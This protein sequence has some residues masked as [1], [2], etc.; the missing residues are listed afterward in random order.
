[1][2]DTSTILTEILGVLTSLAYLYF[3]VKQK[4]W[5][6]PLGILSSAFYIVI[7]Y[8]S[9]LYADMGLQVYY[10]VISVYGWY[11]WL[12]AAARKDN[13]RLAVSR[14][15]KRQL[16]W[17]IL[18]AILLYIILV[19]ALKYVPEWLEI[20]ASDIL[21]W[22]AFTTAVSIIATWMLA[23]KILE[24]WLLWIVVDS[25]SLFL[26]IYKGL[27]YTAFLFFVYTI[28]AIYGYIEWKK[29]KSIPATE[30]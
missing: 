3:S 25:V 2:T 4:I 10:L 20:A 13:K 19:F 8:G 23:R 28:I 18:S 9:C 26:Y 7:F 27:Y 29:S 14:I 1:M 6:W 5:L 22:D 17:M 30:Q 24:H 16:P 12:F 11:Y 21:F 15:K